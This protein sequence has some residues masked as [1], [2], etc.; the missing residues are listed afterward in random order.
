MPIME[1]WLHFSNLMTNGKEKQEVVPK[2]FSCFG[3]GSK[4]KTIAAIVK[5]REIKK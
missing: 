3:T 1:K 5:I 4:T 2:L